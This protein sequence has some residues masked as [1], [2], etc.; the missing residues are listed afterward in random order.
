MAIRRLCV[1]CG[2]SPG[3]DPVYLEL[4]AAVG[5]G[6]AQRGISVVYGG[7]RIGRSSGSSRAT[8]S[9]AKSLTAA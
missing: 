4:A 2:A 9:T 6:L 3:R 1:F 8:W 5:T 7:S